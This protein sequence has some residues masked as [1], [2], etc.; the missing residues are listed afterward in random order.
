M[1]ARFG[2][3]NLDQ[4]SHPA[5]RLPKRG[6]GAASGLSRI[7]INGQVLDVSRT[8]AACYGLAVGVAVDCACE[9]RPVWRAGPCCN[10]RETHSCQHLAAGCCLRPHFASSMRRQYKKMHSLFTT[11]VGLQMCPVPAE[12][13]GAGST[14]YIVALTA[15]LDLGSTP[16]AA[17]HRDRSTRCT[18]RS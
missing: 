5:M 10:L 2:S 16:L 18:T 15:C 12:A 1:L 13:F 11:K 8:L 3:V 4:P 7:L 17:G 9:G 14:I 6:L